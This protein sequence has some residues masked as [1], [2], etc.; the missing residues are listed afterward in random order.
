M[1]WH[2][3]LTVQTTFHTDNFYHQSAQKNYMLVAIL[4]RNFFKIIK[5]TTKNLGNIVKNKQEYL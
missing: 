3:S 4:V 5:N 1:F 2:P